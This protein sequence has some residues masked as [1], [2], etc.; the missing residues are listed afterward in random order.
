M[1]LTTRR[2]YRARYYERRWFLTGEPRDGHRVAS[3]RCVCSIARTAAGCTPEPTSAPAPTPAARPDLSGVWMAFA[4]E[5]PDGGGNAVRYSPRGTGAARRV[6]V[7]VQLD[8]RDGRLVLRDGHAERDAVDGVLSH[9]DRAARVA[10]RDA[11]RARDAGAARLSRWP[12]ASRGLPADRRR[13]LG[14]HVGRRHARH[15]HDAALRVAAPPVA[16][17]GADADRRAR[18]S[19]EARR[20]HGAPVGVR[21]ERR[22]TRSTTTCSWSR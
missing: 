3:R 5:N 18:V 22:E 14:R 1:R 6:R 2:G 7:A 19:H 16:A 4:V 15:R 9:R 8:P 17:H 10:A 20:H 11:G 12:L 21:C 13:P